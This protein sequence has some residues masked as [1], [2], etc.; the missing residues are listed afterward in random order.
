[1]NRIGYFYVAAVV[2]AC[3]CSGG[4]HRDSMIGTEILPGSAYRLEI[5]DMPESRRFELSLSSLTSSSICIS[6]EEWPNAR[7]ELSDGS[8]RAAVVLSTGE[9][10][11][12]KDYNFGYCPG[13]CGQL[14]VSGYQTLTGYITYDAIALQSLSEESAPKELRFSVTPVRCAR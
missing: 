2:F 13:G 1:M 5:R 4:S 14:A 12:A 7:G 8:Q 3:G 6:V 10:R 9:V 11:A